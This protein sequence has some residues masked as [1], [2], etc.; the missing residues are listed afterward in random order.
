MACFLPGSH[1]IHTVKT[2]T[3]GLLSSRGHKHRTGLQGKAPSASKR[4]PAASALSQDELLAKIDSLDWDETVT[5]D[6]A[7][8]RNGKANTPYPDHSTSNWRVVAIVATLAVFLAV[9]Y[10]ALA[11]EPAP[12]I[13]ADEA[14]TPISSAAG[15]PATANAGDQ[16]PVAPEISAAAVAAA[17]ERRTALYAHAIEQAEAKVQ[18]KADARR[19]L[20]EAREAER[21]RVQAQQERERREKEEA[22]A[23]AERDAEEAAR[24]AKAREQAAAAKGPASPQ[25]SC[26]GETGVIARGFCEARAC[27]KAEWRSHPFCVKRIEEQ[28]RSFGQ[29]GG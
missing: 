16:A 11:P 20:R 6:T 13:T 24:S 5:P 25:E 28:L 4:R 17:E 7:S 22:R 19:K 12:R 26:A 29:G 15:S 21:T 3:I 2:P 27:G 1:A 14:P 8:P 9:L 23:R 10:F 18:Q